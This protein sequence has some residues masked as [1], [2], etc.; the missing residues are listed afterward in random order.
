[1]GKNICQINQLWEQ[2]A[3]YTL[4]TEHKWCRC[5]RRQHRIMGK[6]LN[7]GVD[8][9]NW[10]WQSLMAAFGLVFSLRKLVSLVPWFDF[11]FC[12]IKTKNFRIILLWNFHFYESPRKDALSVT[13]SRVF[14]EFLGWVRTEWGMLGFAEGIWSVETFP[15]LAVCPVIC[16]PLPKIVHMY[17]EKAFLYRKWHAGNVPGQFLS[18]AIEA[19]L[20]SGKHLVRMLICWYNGGLIYK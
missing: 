19:P 10:M 4:C 8:W 13:S 3:N 7:Y 14:I 2:V 9:I 17:L 15:M 5:C 16:P 20:Q 12:R 18:M 1:V 6:L 11:A